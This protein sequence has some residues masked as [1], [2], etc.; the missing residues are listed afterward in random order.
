M[1]N[2]LSLIPL[3][4]IQSALLAAGQVLLKYGLNR[5]LPFSMTFDFWK[6]VFANW[7]F[8]ACGLCYGAGSIL[9]FYIIKHFPFSMAYPM[10]SLSYV[11]GMIAAI[12]FF[13]EDVSLAKWV[14]VLL[15]ML[16]C[17]F[18]AK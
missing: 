15:I 4:V 8:A 1:M 2:T 11:F 7:Q 10:V 17:Y 14:G 9:W 5:M 6:S 13:H 3:A 16:G 12:V 18:I